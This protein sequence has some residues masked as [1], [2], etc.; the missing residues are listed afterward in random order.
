MKSKVVYITGEEAKIITLEAE[1]SASETV[2]MHGPRH[3]AETLGKN[4][5][6]KQDDVE[7]FV[8]ELATLLEQEP[9]RIL[10]V[11]P[12]QTKT[13]LMKHI[14]RQ[15]PQLAKSIVGLETMDKA[16]TQQVVHFAR[17]Y[18]TKLGVY[19]AI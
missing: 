9:A 2:R 3:P 7:R 11:G 13:R 14:E 18:F 17:S 12:A 1:N 19:E 8:H 15:H 6:K 4:H 10:L 5:P 16:S